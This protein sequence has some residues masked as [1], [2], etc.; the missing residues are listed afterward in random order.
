MKVS[1]KLRNLKDDIEGHRTSLFLFRIRERLFKM[2]CRHKKG[3]LMH[4]V[5]DGH[6]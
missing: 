1:F 2:L 4:D 6:N 3:I 5:N